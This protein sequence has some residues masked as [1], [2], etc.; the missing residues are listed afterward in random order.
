MSNEIT[1]AF[2]KQY[3]ANVYMLM[4]QKGSRLRNSVRLESI[5]GEERFF[6]QIGST[7]AVKKTTR[8]GDTPL[9]ESPHSRRQVQ[10]DDY[11]V[12]DLIDVQDKLRTL[13]DFQSPYA[14]SMAFALGREI[15]KEIIRAA[16]ADAKTGKTGSTTVALPS[17]Q[18]VAVNATGLTLDKLIQARQILRANEADPDEERFIVLRAKDM[19]TLLNTTEIKSADYNTIK[20]LVQGG[21][22]TFMGFRFLHTE[23]IGDHLASVQVAGTDVGLL[24]YTKSALLMAM[25]KDINTRMTERADKS[26]S[27]QVYCSMSMGATRMEEKGVVEIAV[28]V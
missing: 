24:C 11:E 6:D 25:A 10:F 21:V 20:T 22:D 28:V 2:V 26:Y 4:Q 16:F 14:M 19:S 12:A 1:T 9:I 15:D 3:G 8:H 7:T 17:G 23:L 13:A 18:K 27:M 5:N